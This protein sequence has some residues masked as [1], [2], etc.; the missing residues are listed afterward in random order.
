[1][2]SP[3]SPTSL[4]ALVRERRRELKLTQEALAKR[5]GFRRKVVSM[6]ENGHVTDPMLSTLRGLSRELGVEMIDLASLSGK[7]SSDA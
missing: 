7:R 5:A 6:I 1:M 4:A 3:T 2:T